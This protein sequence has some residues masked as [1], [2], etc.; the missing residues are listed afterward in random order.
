MDDAEKQLRDLDEKLGALLN[1]RVLRQVECASSIETLGR[2]FEAARAAAEAAGTGW[3]PNASLR[4]LYQ[5][6]HGAVLER[7]QRLVVAYL[8]PPASY[9]HAAASQHFGFA[10]HFVPLMTIADVF[11]EVEA[12]RAGYGV[13][14]VENT[15]EGAVQHT[16]DTFIESNLGIGAE[17]ALRIS[18]NLLSQ[19]ERLEE[20]EQ[21]YSHPQALAQCQRWLA[22]H[23]PSLPQNPTSSTAAAAALCQR[24]PR[25][26]AIASGEAAALYGLRIL[27][28]Q[29]EDFSQNYTRF[30][31]LS[32]T[33]SPPTGRDKTSLVCGIPD[34]PGALY[35]T[36]ELL[37]SA[38]INMQKIESRP[39]KARPWE[40]VFFID[41]EGHGEEAHVR[42]ALTTMRERCSFLKVLGSYP[43]ASNVERKGTG[44]R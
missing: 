42:Q 23:V 3:F 28:S 21:L 10:A 5:H 31:V 44:T 6:L 17:I 40:Y 15:T 27:A 32:S 26:A 33:A 30:L 38:N 14:P 4:L 2:D 18:H 25:A 41:L 8:G 20:V 13:V 19:C 1:E 11:R 22:A 9:T 16:L 29:I 43:Q 37:A 12:G 34:K 36:L 35:H 24:E 7:L 39:S